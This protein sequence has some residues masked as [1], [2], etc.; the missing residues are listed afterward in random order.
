MFPEPHFLKKINWLKTK[1]YRIKESFSVCQSVQ[2]CGLWVREFEVHILVGLLGL[3]KLPLPSNMQ[4][5][6]D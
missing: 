3:R 2:F 1:S 4:Q 6:L 5:M